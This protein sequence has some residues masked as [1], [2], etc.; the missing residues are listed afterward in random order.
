[1]AARPKRV[2]KS[3]SILNQRSING[4]LES[5]LLKSGF[6][7]GTFDGGIPKTRRR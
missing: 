1:V 7:N 6:R 2:Y 4:S 3:G 5:T